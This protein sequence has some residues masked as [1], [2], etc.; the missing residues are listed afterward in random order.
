ME[1]NGQRLRD[2]IDSMLPGARINTPRDG[3]L[4]NTISLTIEG[5]H[6]DDLIVSLD[7]EG[8]YVSSG[9]ACASG[10][11]EPSHVLMAMGF[12]EDE[13]R[14]TIRIS[15]RAEHTGAELDAACETIA[16]CVGR[17]RDNLV[18]E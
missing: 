5:V 10:K 11:P 14:R 16:R 2:S 15:L 17:M 8:V 1:A 4:P 18:R 12:S 6:A 3:A 7:L 13:A 9:A